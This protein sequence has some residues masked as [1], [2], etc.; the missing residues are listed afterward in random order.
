MPRAE[1][2]KLRSS[3]IKKRSSVNF[4]HSLKVKSA[5]KNDELKLKLQLYSLEMKKKKKITN[6]LLY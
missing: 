3:D 5:A 2:S 4:N 6:I 1:S